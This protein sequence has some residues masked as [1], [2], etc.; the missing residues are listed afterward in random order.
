MSKV[1]L[2]GLSIKEL[3]E[4]NCEIQLKLRKNKMVDIKVAI[5]NNQKYVGKCYKKQNDENTQYI[6]VVSALSS[7]EY[8]LD[9]LVF[10]NN[11]IVERT[12]NRSMHFSP[13]DIFQP[14]DYEGIHIEDLP[15]LCNSRIL[16]SKKVISE[17]KEI[18]KEEF[19]EEMDNYIKLL[20]EKLDNND[21]ND[22][23][24]AEYYMKY[25]Q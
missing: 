15:L 10:E 12:L 22:L 19:Y 25:Y 4:L 17:Y 14:I 1:N 5:D 21:F 18:T 23:S 11:I 7:N 24:S 8:H 6:M 2:N 9:C 13:Q 3:E 20:K 16:N